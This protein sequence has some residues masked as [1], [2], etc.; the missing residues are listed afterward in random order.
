MRLPNS[1]NLPI[2]RHLLAPAI[3]RLASVGRTAPL[4]CDLLQQRQIEMWKLVTPNE[5]SATACEALLLPA[6]APDAQWYCCSRWQRKLS[7]KLNAKAFAERSGARVAKLYWCGDRPEDIPF[8]SL[9]EEYVVKTTFGWSSQQVILIRRQKN[10]FTSQAASPDTLTAHFRRLLGAPPC[11]FAQV[12]VEELLITPTGDSPN[13]YKL[14]CFHGEPQYIQVIDRVHGTHVWYDAN[15]TAQR[16]QMQLA[17][18]T[19]RPVSRPDCLA[20]LLFWGRRLSQA[21]NYPFV[22]VDLYVTT[23][24]VVF[25][26][27]THT[28]FAGP[29]RLHYTPFANRRMGALWLR[30]L[31]SA[32]GGRKIDYAYVSRCSGEEGAPSRRFV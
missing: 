28:P 9:P 10:L 29:S 20:E 21:Y 27:F 3:Y 13:D 16:D 17:Y 12:M 26:E 5:H 30:D 8:S 23:R 22:R 14:Y 24:G 7:N 32:N 18:R 25:G 11:L 2:I 19:G 6:A 4:F 1:I 15:W 31:K